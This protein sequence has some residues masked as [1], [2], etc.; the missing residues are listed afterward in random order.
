MKFRIGLA[1]L[2][3]LALATGCTMAAKE[4]DDELVKAGFTKTKSER[5]GSGL[6]R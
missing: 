3:S 5:T 6:R 2:A 1:A 4:E